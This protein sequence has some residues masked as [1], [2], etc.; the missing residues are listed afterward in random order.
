MTLPDAKRE[1]LRW[2]GPPEQA[3]RGSSLGNAACFARA[4]AE[5]NLDGLWLP[6]N[7]RWY[8]GELALRVTDPTGGTLRQ[9]AFAPAY[10]AAQYAEEAGARWE[11]RLC[12]AASEPQVYFWL[13]GQGFPRGAAVAIV[14]DWRVGAAR[15]ETHRA[16]PPP[17]DCQR[18]WSVEKL[19][20]NCLRARPQD[21]GEDRLTLEASHAISGFVWTE[22][23]RARLTFAVPV[24][25]AGALDFW[26]CLTARAEAADEEQSISASPLPAA[27]ACARAEQALAEI[28]GWEPT[29][30]KN[31]S[32]V[33]RAIAWGK[34]GSR[35]VWHRYATG[36]E[37]FT[38]DPPG[39]TIVTRDAAWF[40]FGADYFA[41]RRSRA[42]LETL[43]RHAIYPGGKIAEYVRLSPEGVTRDDYALNLNDA[44]PL[45]VLA[46]A[47]HWVAT[48]SAEF[49]EA[50][51]PM[52]RGAAEWILAQRREDGLVWCDGRGTDVHGIGGWR[53]IIPGYRLAGALTE[54]NAEC[55][56][57]LRV[58]ARLAE[59]RGEA[60]DAARFAA[61][62]ERLNAAMT[63]LV[64][65]QTGL[66]LLNRDENGPNASL[67]VD[68]ALPALFEAGPEEAR[69]RTLL[70][71]VGP[72]FRARYGLRCL[73]CEDPAYHPRFGWGLMGGSWPNATAWAAAALAPY[74]P[75]L[76]RELAE[77]IAR[78]LF[79]EN[80]AAPGVSVPGQFPEWFDGA[81]GESAGMS[82]SPWMPATYVW[83]VQE[84]L[85]GRPP[86]WKAGD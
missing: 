70:R 77:E 36:D 39:V 73:S 15:S 26:L 16:Q 51:Y 49:L 85:A 27:E 61:E 48:N 69:L 53:N 21:E 32:L 78:A 58:T 38:N 30:L 55:V 24:D 5:A 44:T 1:W 80:W 72:D 6:A 10:Q 4:D 76:A 79:P 17:R 46:V 43:A 12:V 29:E 7:D 86:V 3:R 35:R 33:E 11:K 75:E 14:C 84:R 22:P 60:A 82:L 63:Q 52:A 23:A 18:Q 41:P 45:F 9:V 8:T 62:S 42:L 25:A 81:T 19:A 68:L 74:R 28:V 57:A 65:P 20:P 54:L 40:L 34:I 31:V 83:L 66:L 59:A 37:G 67:A 47:H 64:A 2:E 13:R 56:A 71:L 50:F